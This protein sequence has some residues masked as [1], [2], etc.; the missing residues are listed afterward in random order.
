MAT[1][2]KTSRSA[3]GGKSEDEIRAQLAK[4][5]GQ[6]RGFNVN[7][8]E[9]VSTEEAIVEIGLQAEGEPPIHRARMKRIGSEWRFDGWSQAGPT[10]R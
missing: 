9:P 10:T 4:D 6:V 2:R 1:L 5:F 7:K 3:G 8:V